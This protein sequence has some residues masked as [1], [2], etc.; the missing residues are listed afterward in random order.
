MPTKAQLRRTSEARKFYAE[1]GW[2][3]EKSEAK[4]V[5]KERFGISEITSYNIIRGFKPAKIEIAQEEPKP[6]EL[7][8]TED[9]SMELIIPSNISKDGKEAFGRALSIISAQSEKIM[10]LTMQNENLQN[11]LIHQTRTNKALKGIAREMLE[12]LS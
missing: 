9:N 4:R 1:S 12:A 11:S 3:L 5:L 10:R 2:R 8:L 7:A 6:K